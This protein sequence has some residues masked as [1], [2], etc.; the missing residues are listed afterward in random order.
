M[1][2]KTIVATALLGLGLAASAQAADPTANVVFKGLVGNSIP[3]DNLI[4]TGN[5]GALEIADGA[6]LVNQDGT[7]ET[8]Q[9]IQV[10]ARD[11]DSTTEVVSDV[12]TSAKWKVTGITALFG[13]NTSTEA[14]I[15]VTD[16]GL[17][18]VTLDEDATEFSTETSGELILSVANETPVTDVDNY[19]AVTVSVAIT[20]TTGA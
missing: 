3:G 10:E 18:A 13:A 11:Y 2:N 1:F 9:P 7:F 20:A 16:A 19:S 12:N 6:L 5:N 14:D 4:I 8:T 17:G 15:S